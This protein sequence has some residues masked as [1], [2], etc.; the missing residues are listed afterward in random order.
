MLFYQFLSCCS[1][2]Q[3]RFHLSTPTY[4]AFNVRLL[5]PT[6]L[7]AACTSILPLDQLCLMFASLAACTS[8]LPLYQCVYY[9]LLPTMLNVHYY[10]PCSLFPSTKYAFSLF[11]FYWVRPL[12]GQF[13]GPSII[14]GERSVGLCIYHV[15]LSCFIMYFY[16]VVRIYNLAFAYQHQHIMRLMFAYFCQQPWSLHVH[17]YCR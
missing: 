12:W 11:S 4:N 10:Q 8:I 3:P 16:H 1:Y 9:S 2:I 7:V 5:L 14:V 17:P 6:T 15:F 13:V